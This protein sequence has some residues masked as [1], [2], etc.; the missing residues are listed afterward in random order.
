MKTKED[1]R[2]VLEGEEVSFEAC[3]NLMDDEIRAYLHTFMTGST[4]QS[5]MDAYVD[6]HYKRFGEHFTI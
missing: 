2:V 3:V 4:A 6:E 5:F 1:E